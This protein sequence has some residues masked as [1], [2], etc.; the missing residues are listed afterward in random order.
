MIS[1]TELTAISDVLLK[2]FNETASLNNIRRNIF[3]FRHIK[4]GFDL[5]KKVVD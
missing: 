5:I 2:S 4:F 3:A 1:D